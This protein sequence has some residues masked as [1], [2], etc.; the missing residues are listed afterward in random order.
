MNRA[1]QRLSTNPYEG[2]VLSIGRQ[3]S[4]LV[5]FFYTLRVFENS[6][7]VALWSAIETCKIK[8][9]EV[10]DLKNNILV[11]KFE[12]L[13]QVWK[14]TRGSRLQQYITGCPTATGSFE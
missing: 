6:N 8:K 2:Q 11:S 3:L 7:C 1:E 9:N 10:I 12:N 13:T 4:K 5:L 14:G